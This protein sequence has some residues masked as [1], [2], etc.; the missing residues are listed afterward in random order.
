MPAKPAISWLRSLS[1]SHLFTGKT[2][3]ADFLPAALE[4]VESPPRP[5]GRIIGFC[6]MLFFAIALLWAC[7]GT[8]DIIAT[9]PGKVVPTGRTKVIQPLESGIVHAIHIQDGQQVKA[10]DVLIEIDTTV[11]ASERDRLKNDYMQAMLDTA[12]LKAALDLDGDPVARFVA[13]EG[14][15]EAQITLQKSMLLNQVD[16]IQAKLGDLD[17]QIKQNA[18]NR[19]A[20]ASTIS[21]L[22]DSIPYLEQR[23]DARKSLLDKG[24]GSKL[25][26]LTIE[27]DLIE[28]Q[29]E[30]RVQKGRLAE[31][32]GATASHKQQR[33]QAEDEY[34]HTTLKDLAE[35]EQKSSSL[36]EQLLQ[37]AQKYRL[38]TLTA[39]VDGTVQQL[40]VHTEGGVVTPA[41]VL[42]SIVPADSHLEIEAMVSN[43]DIGFVHAGEE[44]EVKIDT[45]TFTRYGLLHG[46]VQSVSQDAIVQQKP[47]DRQD[48]KRRA[49]DESDSSEP[50]G[51]EL[52]YSARISLDKTRMQIDDRL[53]NLGPGM[54]VTVEIKTGSRHIIEYLLSPL[55]RHKQQAMREM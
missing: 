16:E 9:A 31:A 10:G 29:Q 28:H 19:N 20:V 55:L 38:Q 50:Q 17:Q 37:A 32:E 22:T 3:E 34:K 14:A 30:L 33:L 47:Q 11:S 4:I 6:L 5:A 40:A 41:Q 13:P 42:M 18:G 48:E 25:D 12:R 35:A 43:K 52:V 23:A 7:I 45:F 8:V 49:G 54:A 39:P 1:E 44:A 27:Q 36:H 21:K 46:K 26:Y 24:Y 2:D 51:Q 53:V 15:S